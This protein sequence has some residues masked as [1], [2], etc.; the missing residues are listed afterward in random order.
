MRAKQLTSILAKA[1]AKKLPILLK[2]PPG[3]GKTALVLAAAK[4]AGAEVVLMH[5]VVCDPTDFKG[6][7]AIVNG[8]AVFLPYGELNKLIKA[9]KPTICFFDDLGQAPAAVQAAAMHP[10]HAREI[11]GKK[12]SDHVVFMAA[13][14]RREDKAGVT[15]L[16]EP[17]KSRFATILNLEAD[18]NDWTEWAISNE[19]PPILIAFCRFKPGLFLE[20]FKPTLDIVNSA[21]PRTIE[22]V[23]QLWEADIRDL[24]SLA[25]AAGSNFATQFLA[26]VRIWE[27]LPDIDAIILNPD[28]AAIPTEMSAI[29]AIVSALTHR[30]TPAN[31]AQIIRYFRRLPSKEY[32]ILGVKDCCR[33]CPAAAKNAEYIK[34]QCEC[35]DLLN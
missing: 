15:S 32:A 34:F 18:L 24:E 5:P 4:E 27:Q 23:G 28:T 13:T 25:G 10:I 11:G 22:H 31:A 6:L 1:I 7:P 2:G 14:N 3:V 17:L 30:V 16:L 33:K 26:F 20:P 21:C 29:Y 12:I 19:V 9:K 8:G 35:G